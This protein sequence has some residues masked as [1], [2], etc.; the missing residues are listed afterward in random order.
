MTKTEWE[1][2][3]ERR[4]GPYS[5]NWKFVCPVCGNVQDPDDF[6]PYK[7]QGAQPDSCTKE[8]LG[9]YTGRGGFEG[10]G[11]CNYAGYGLFRL[12]PIRVDCGDGKEPMHCFDF[13]PESP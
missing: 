4:F 1:A 6:R 3:A 10:E 12:S 13:A 8:C 9:R 11:P 2:E 5:N 7:D